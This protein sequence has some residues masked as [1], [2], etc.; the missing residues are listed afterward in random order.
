VEPNSEGY[1]RKYSKETLE[2]KLPKDIKAADI[3]WLTLWCE[4]F[5][6]SFGEVK[7]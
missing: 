6:V 5:G 7:F 4:A 2:V 1:E 3:K